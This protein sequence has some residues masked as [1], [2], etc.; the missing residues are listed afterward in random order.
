LLFE[1]KITSEFNLYA[2]YPSAR[3]LTARIRA[4]ID[5]LVTVLG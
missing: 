3:H 1:D 5:H 2:V 4:L